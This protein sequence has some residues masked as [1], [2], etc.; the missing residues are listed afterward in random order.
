MKEKLIKPKNKQKTN[1]INSIILLILGIILATNSNKIITLGFQLI[2]ICIITFGIYKIIKY[3]NLK[4][5]FKIEDSETMIS[6]IITITVG[7]LIV[8]LASILEIG[9]RYII[10]FYL[11]L[12]A[13]GKIMIAKTILDHKNPIFISNTI[14]SI[15][16]LILGLYTIFVANAALIIVG[17][18]LII[19]SLVDLFTNL[20]K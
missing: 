15:I 19:S 12:N 2:G 7:I 8:V 6:G 1:S 11:I 17:I 14:A 13:L 20:K 3:I 16:L 4:K 18:F 9:L 5:Q 10:G